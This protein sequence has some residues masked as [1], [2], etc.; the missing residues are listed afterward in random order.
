[1]NDCGTNLKITTVFC[2][3]KI[4]FNVF[5]YVICENL[6][7]VLFVYFYVKCHVLKLKNI[8]EINTSDSRVR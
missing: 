4:K 2:V 5:E 3:I 7:I 8:R 1:M 6:I